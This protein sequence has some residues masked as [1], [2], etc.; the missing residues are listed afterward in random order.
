MRADVRPSAAELTAAVQQFLDTEI[1]PLV[2]GEQNYQLRIAVNLLTIV[3]R[4][5]ELGNEHRQREQQG[6]S[7]LLDSDGTVED[8]NKA[9]CEAIGQRQFSITD[10]ALLKHLRQ[11]VLDRLTISNPRYSAY[12]RAKGAPGA[13][14]MAQNAE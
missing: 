1:K 9:L 14:P 2:E 3:G 7:G 10:S 6:L 11:S 8:L 12:L 5:I 13:H 4:E